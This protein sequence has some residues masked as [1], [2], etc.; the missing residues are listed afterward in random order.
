MGKT[1]EMGDEIPWLYSFSF[2]PKTDYLN[3]KKK[4]KF[5]QTFARHMK[6]RDQS[7]FQKAVSKGG[8]RCICMG[9]SFF[10]TMETNATL[11]SSY[12]CCQLL[13]RVG[14]FATTWTSACH[15]SLSFTISWSLLKRMSIELV[16]PSNY[17]ILCHLSN[18]TP[19]KK[20]KNNIDI[21]IFMII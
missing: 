11:L 7:H 9:D 8:G 1:L 3:R 21:N 2:L 13:S 14:L 20:T 19:I 5:I 15:A 4:N 10:C 16:M 18:Y 12:F 17:L 6:I